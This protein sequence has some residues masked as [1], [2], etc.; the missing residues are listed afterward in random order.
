MLQIPVNV[1]LGTVT[2][3]TDG[4][5][6]EKLQDFPSLYSFFFFPRARLVALNCVSKNHSNISLLYVSKQSSALKAREKKIAVRWR[7]G[8]PTLTSGS[9]TESFGKTDVRRTRGPELSVEGVCMRK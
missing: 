3:L 7:G 6:A 8:G 4:L 5:S 1:T 2:A 9:V